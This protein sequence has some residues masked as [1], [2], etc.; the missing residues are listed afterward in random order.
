MIGIDI[1]SKSIKIVETVKA[2]KGWQLKTSGTVGFTGNTPDKMV[3]EI[4]F[5]NLA[6]LIKKI[7]KQIKISSSAINLGIPER[8]VFTRIIKFPYLTDEEIV[9]AIKW[10]AEQYIPIPLEEAVVEHVILEKREKTAEVYV[11]LIAVPKVVVE[12]YV[13]IIRLA[14]L[15]PV[16]AESELVAQARSIAPDLGTSLILDIGSMAT[17]MGIIKDGRLFFTR[18][19]PIAGE[20]FTRAVS[21]SMG[22]RE[23]QAEEYKK[24]YGL[25]ANELEGKIKASLDPVV[26]MIADEVKKAIH[27]YQTEGQVDIP[28]SVVLT[29]GSSSLPQ[30]QTFFTDL[31]NMETVIGNPFSKITLD[32]ETKENLI[33]FQSYYAGAVG[34]SMRE[35]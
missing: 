14:N 33:P 7:A 1:G 22:L 12:R 35:E 29:G 18:S 2:G 27:F 8:L 10:E 23:D 26:R 30:V 15:N 4:E 19:I 25:T 17:N 31:L 5:N 3:E 34:L 9:S 6:E 16:A 24:T 11:L 21:Q 32:P 28:T 20:A 13:K